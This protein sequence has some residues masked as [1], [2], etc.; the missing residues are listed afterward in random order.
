MDT[1]KNRPEGKRAV[2]E[3]ALMGVTRL[4]GVMGYYLVNMGT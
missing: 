2:L 1:K 4:L 3:G